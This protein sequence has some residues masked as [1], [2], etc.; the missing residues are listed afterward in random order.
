MRKLEWRMQGGYPKR[1]SAGADS[2]NAPA[3]EVVC[4][5]SLPKFRPREDGGQRGAGLPRS[6]GKPGQAAA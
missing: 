2:R 4:A 3:G 6:M 5:E 1:L